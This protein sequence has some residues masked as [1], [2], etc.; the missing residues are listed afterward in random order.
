MDPSSIPPG[1]IEQHN[2]GVGEVSAAQIAIRASEL[3]RSDGRREPNEG[4]FQQARQELEG[5]VWPPGA[6][7]EVAGQMEDVVEWDQPAH[8][9]GSRAPRVG[10]TDETSAPEQL[11]LEGVEEADHDRRL[12]SAE[13]DEEGLE[14]ENGE[15]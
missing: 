11:V 9:S 1:R 14:G 4:D 13:E 3:A 15:A 6:P 2:A 7:E 10:L 5:L 8:A 12:A